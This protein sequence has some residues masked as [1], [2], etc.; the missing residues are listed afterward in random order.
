[1]VAPRRRSPHAHRAG[2]GSSTMVRHIF[3]SLDRRKRRAWQFA[4]LATWGVLR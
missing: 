1:M 2:G 4:R 3:T